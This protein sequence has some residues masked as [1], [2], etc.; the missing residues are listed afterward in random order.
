MPI[1]N[2]SGNFYLLLNY[3]KNK[4]KEELTWENIKTKINKT[5]DKE[6]IKYGNEQASI[7]NSKLQGIRE[8][9]CVGTCKET[10]TQSN[11]E[12]K[13]TIKY[14]NEIIYES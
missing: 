14:D 11:E 6:V 7:H 3:I 12:I 5:I 13:S 8:G 9:D 2:S 4:V 1:F 10:V